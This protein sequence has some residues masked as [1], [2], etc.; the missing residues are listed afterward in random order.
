MNRFVDIESLIQASSMISLGLPDAPAEELPKDIKDVL[1][2]VRSQ[3]GHMPGALQ[4]LG[5]ARLEFDEL[6]NAVERLLALAEAAAALPEQDFAG[7][8]PLEAD[9]IRHSKTV[10]AIAGRR[11]YQGPDLSLRTP[12]LARAALRT[13]SHLIPV[14][15]TM[16]EQMAEQEHLILEAFRGT[17]GFLNAMIVSFPTSTMTHQITDLLQRVVWLR[18]ELEHDAGIGPLPGSRELH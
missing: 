6:R 1:D 10:A 16:V 11:S 5:R 18:D 2:A 3:M 17:L 12:A 14:I 7:C 9:F 13:L 15:R 8:E 4:D